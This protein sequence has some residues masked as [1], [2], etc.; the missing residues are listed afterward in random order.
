MR[1][2]LIT[3]FFS[4][5]TS[6]TFYQNSGYS[7]I[8][9][10]YDFIKTGLSKKDY[11]LQELGSP[12][13]KDETSWVYFGEKKKKYSFLRAKA[14]KRNILFVEFDE[15]DIVSSF[16]EFDLNSQNTISFNQDYTITD[17]ENKNSFIEM[18]KSTLA[19]I[20]QISPN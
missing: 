18:L 12:T 14:I 3:I 5:L 13:I 8:H 4:F 11:I 2:L 7:F 15:N 20:G 16:K 1:V 10:N 6:C 9:E 19:N 17:I